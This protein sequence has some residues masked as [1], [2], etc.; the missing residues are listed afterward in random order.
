MG[1]RGAQP[2]SARAIAACIWPNGEYHV[3]YLVPCTGG[4][5]R[6]NDHP[7]WLSYLQHA[8]VFAGRVSAA[9]ARRSSWRTLYRRGGTGTVLSQ[10]PGTDCRAL[11]ASSL[12]LRAGGATLQ[13]W[14]SG[15]LPARW[16]YRIS[17]AIRPASEVAR[18]PHRTGRDR[19]GTQPAPDRT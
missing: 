13:D 9:R 3:L 19:G 4:P 7:N 14:R 16:Q 1:Q 15:A 2:W 11:S 10:P 5:G 18:L 6:S 17:R 12:E 8:D